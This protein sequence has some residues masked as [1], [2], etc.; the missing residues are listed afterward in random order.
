MFEFL[1]EQGIDVARCGVDIG[2]DYVK[3][4][5]PANSNAGDSLADYLDRPSH[6]P[7]KAGQR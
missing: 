1:R 4:S 5:P 2:P 7:Q 6:S 3:V